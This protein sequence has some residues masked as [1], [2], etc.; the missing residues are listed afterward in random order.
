LIQERDK[1][2]IKLSN[3]VKKKPTT[4]KSIEPSSNP[5]N[6]SDKKRFK[7][8][9]L[10]LGLGTRYKKGKKNISPWWK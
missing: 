6:K 3:S 2:T 1:K 4:K 7:L 5:V 8:T 10:G 9:S